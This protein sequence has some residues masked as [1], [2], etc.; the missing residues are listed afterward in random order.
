[1]SKVVDLFHARVVATLRQTLPATQVIDGD[2]ELA[3]DLGIDSLTMLELIMSLEDRFDITI[4]LELIAR[5]ATVDDLVDTLKS[6][7]LRCHDRSIA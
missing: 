4:P 1:M 5:V 3:G 2:S 7:L 6:S